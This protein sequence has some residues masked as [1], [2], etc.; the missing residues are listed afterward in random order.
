MTTEQRLQWVAVPTGVL[1]DG[2]LRISVAVTPRLR[3]DD[4]TTLAV[5]N[6]LLDWPAAL[7]AAT[8]V[9]A[10]D[11]VAVPAQRV[12]ATAE[13]DLWTALFP[14][15]TPVNPYRFADY[16]DRPLVSF[17][18]LKLTGQLRSLYATVAAAGPDRLPAR[19]TRRTVEP[20]VFGLDDMLAAV[21]QPGQ[22]RFGELSRELGL[23]GAADQL[24]ATAR[25]ETARRKAVGARG[26]DPVEP[27][28]PDAPFEVERAV[29]FHT[30]PEPEPREMPADG[31]HYRRTVDFHQMVTALGDHPDL[32]RRLGLLVDLAVDAADMPNP[33]GFVSVTPT[34]P[35]AADAVLRENLAHSTA[36]RAADG[37]FVAARRAPVPGVPEGLVALSS[38][39]YG[40]SQ[41]D[42]DGAAL[43]TLAV[44]ITMSQPP[45]SPAGSGLHQ[46]EDAG[47]PALR[48]SGLSIVH[49]GRAASLQNEFVANLD[50]NTAIEGGPTQLWA[51]DLVRGYRLDVFDDATG[52]WRSLHEQVVTATADRYAGGPARLPGEGQVSVSLAGR[53]TPPNQAPDPDGEL[54][55]H[56]TLVTW[57]GWSLSAPRAGAAL[58]RHADAPDAARPETQPAKVSN[59]PQTA[60]GL[61][62]ESAAV[63]G[64][65]PRLRF[66]R[67]YRLRLR[68][69]DLAGSGPTLDEATALAAGY[70]STGPYLRF[71][72]VPAP[73]AVP[74]DRYGEGAS[75]H[76][77]VIRSDV[78]LDP[79]GYAAAFNAEHVGAHPGYEPV[80]T[81]HVAPPKAS[82]D[83]V[84]KH[85]LFDPAI[86]SD[87]QPPTPEVVAEIAAAYTIARRERGT[88]DD[89]DAPGAEPVT[90]PAANGQ[91]GGRYVIHRTEQLTLPYLP[92]PLATGVM[93]FGLP[94]VGAGDPYGISFTGPTWHQ[95]R[96]LRLRLAAGDEPPNWDEPSRTLTVQLPQATTARVRMASKVDQL[97][98]LGMLAWCETELA[99][100]DRDRVLQSMKENRCWLTTPWHDLELVHAVQHPLEA[101]VIADFRMQKSERA[102]YADLAGEVALHLGS[103]EKLDLTASWT[104][105]IDDIRED[106]PRDLDC[107]TTVFSLPMATVALVP[108]DDRPAAYRFRDAGRVLLFDSATARELGVPIPTPHQFSDTKYHHVRYA[109]TAATPF[110]EDFP[111]G[112]IEHPE[113]LSVT[114]A[115]VTID[116]P[117]SARPQLPDLQYVVPTLGW[118]RADEDGSSVIR[119]RGGGLRIWLGRG[120][121]SSGSGELLG[122]VI[123]SDLISPRGTDYPFVSLIGQDPIRA[124]ALVRN[125]RATSLPGDTKVA[126]GIPIVGTP[127][128]GA[129]IV[130]YKPTWDDSTKR[131]F[132][133]VDID[134]GDAYTPF[135]RLALVRYQPNSLPRCE[136]SG[137]VLADIV[138]PVP[139][140]TAT[141]TRDPADPLALTLTVAGPSYTAV[142]G[143][144]PAQSDDAV[145]PLVTASV[146]RADPAVADD[147]LR[148]QT[149]E[150]TVVTLPRIL[151]G[152]TATWT[153]RL[154]V[155]ADDG[156][157]RVLVTEQERLFADGTSP[158]T[159]QIIQR[160]VY[161]AALPL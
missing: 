97:D 18:V 133:D 129:T 148:W 92:D 54:Y 34:F 77:L 75:L 63:R 22:S 85:G 1:D 49:T 81:R 65:L 40:V 143:K 32:L 128:T 46:P 52:R 153:G 104:D 102:T 12:S 57:D 114:S 7:A 23:A 89:P 160:V 67:S 131:W 73:A 117:S 14:P 82:F 38:G 59:D 41:V 15:E 142:R 74:T 123:G 156:D 26:G 45:V 134:T 110:R 137:V 154:S 70:L 122:V 11:G 139:D 136:V 33:T 27:L 69:V 91:S 78:G 109:F 95:A 84:E 56:E 152:T 31:E 25:T 60:M 158:D 13:S 6:D 126:A 118:S 141:L 103:T 100:N 120:W 138:Q 3:S 98:L 144:G 94:G 132:C 93:F 105:P 130:G 42:V 112:W 113:R 64:T 61:R 150:E 90:I 135:L 55:V 19:R 68:E 24:L 39:G 53:I 155:P 44:A 151:V 71:E 96:P 47:L 145:M 9:V 5:Y 119:R 140:R 72:P 17:D 124:G 58:S 29:L 80:D 88:F 106:H 108:D 62:L 161:A 36:F 159:E 87:G 111:V 79:A 2:R 86:G 115:I 107:T 121:W 99:G 30:S 43:K 149:I 48:T 146:Q 35:P 10:V 51:E 21:V 76:R 4:G 101:P 37:R 66:G 157:L 8:F 20:I 116:I 83:L 127:I 147:V 50:L 28:P 125:L 16:A